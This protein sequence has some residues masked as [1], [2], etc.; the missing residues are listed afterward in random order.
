MLFVVLLGCLGAVGQ[1][2]VEQPA[3][4]P[5]CPKRAQGS[6]AIE[7]RESRVVE[8]D[9]R[10]IPELNSMHDEADVTTLSQW[11]GPDDSRWQLANTDEEMS[12]NPVRQVTRQTPYR[13]CATR[14]VRS[15]PTGPGAP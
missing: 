6:L 1:V 11:Q 5:A 2:S 4:K 12:Y 8:M 7:C 9:Y 10:R 13:R 3:S 15:S 14:P